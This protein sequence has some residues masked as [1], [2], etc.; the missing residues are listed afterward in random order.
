MTHPAEHDVDES[1]TDALARVGIVVTDEG[2]A[3][4]R[5]RLADAER[6]W[7]AERR[8]ALREQLGRPARRAA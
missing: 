7:P 2:K 1:L 8:A 6:E 4:A 5:A 3:R